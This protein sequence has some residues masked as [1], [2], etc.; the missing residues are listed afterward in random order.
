MKTLFYS[1]ILS[2][3]F[4]GSSR[5]QGLEAVKASAGVSFGA[6]LNASFEAIK[7]KDV[8]AIVEPCRI[9]DAQ[10]FRAVELGEA[11][12]MLRA[13]A[14]ALGSRAGVPVTIENRV[15][16][17]GE[18]EPILEVRLG[19]GALSA[20]SFNRDLGYSLKTRRYLLF[21]FPVRVVRGDWKPL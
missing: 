10:F 13:C 1:L 4:A 7:P 8:L 20:T 18:A 16:P 15:T 11:V 2:T 17:S 12:G 9:V 6:E 19:A 21:G 14:K 5:A 3:L